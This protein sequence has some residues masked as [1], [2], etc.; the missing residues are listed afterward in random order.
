MKINNK[1]LI[2]VILIILIS[3]YGIAKS[4]GLWTTTGRKFISTNTEVVH[5]EE[6]NDENEMK[7]NAKT[8]FEELFENGI[9]KENVKE[10]FGIEN[11]EY[12]GNIK[13]FCNNND[14]EFSEVKEIL[15]NKLI[16]L[17]K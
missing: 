8:T 16:D 6:D 1:T 2:I 15:T 3:G 13:E 5:D 14:L 4:T 17:V 11:I 10:I 9:T 12:T 7:V